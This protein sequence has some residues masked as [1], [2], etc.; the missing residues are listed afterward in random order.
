M[1]VNTVQN[2]DLNP[3]VGGAQGTS[4][5]YDF[6]TSPNTRT[7]VSQKV[8]L[9]TPAYGDTN[10]GLSQI[11]V[12]GSF[13]PTHSRDITEVRGIGFG[14]KVAELVPSVS[15]V[16]TASFERA[17]LYLSDL[18]SATGYGSGYNGP[19]RALSHHRWPF[20]IEQ[21]LVFSSLADMDLGLQNVGQQGTI[22]GWD[23]GRTAV[24]FS[25][26]AGATSDGTNPTTQGH[27]AVVTI[28]EAC[29]FN[30]YNFTLSKDEGQI[31]ESGGVTVSDV[32]DLGSLYGEFMAT[33][34]DPTIGQNGSMR[35]GTV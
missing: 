18:F 15:A 32:H 23:S 13:N 19:V 3:Q 35:F 33:G 1:A 2:Q 27:T 9:L 4:Y 34:N 30:D 14:D 29:W 11:G 26:F 25:R 28:Y 16:I 21:Q 12:V 24:D 6:G 7:A 5:I 20:D 17:M 22:P 8:R 31:M 10:K